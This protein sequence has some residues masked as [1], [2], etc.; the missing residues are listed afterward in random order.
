MPICSTPQVEP[1]RLNDLPPSSRVNLRRAIRELSVALGRP[2]ADTIF[3]LQVDIP[4]EELVANDADF[5]GASVRTLGTFIASRGRF[6]LQSEGE[7]VQLL[8]SAATVQLLTSKAS[9]WRD[10]EVQ[11]SGVFSRTLGRVNEKR[12]DNA[13][14]FVI[15][16]SS[17]EPTSGQYSGP[18]RQMSIQ[19]LTTTPFSNGELVRVVGRYRGQN[20]FGDLPVDSR[21]SV[22]D[23]VIRDGLF[24][25]LG[26]GATTRGRR[27]L[28]RRQHGSG[29]SDVARG[30]GQRRGAQGYRLSQGPTCRADAA[31]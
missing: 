23:W 11:V 30:D 19:A 28:A 17:I 5:E 22:Q 3:G 2:A 1:L 10:Q 13:A 20:W 14:R 27:L 9:D 31:T 16:V 21:R 18:A 6:Q 7:S 12:S 8:P 29:Q 15:A 25:R 4:L 24:A 26:D